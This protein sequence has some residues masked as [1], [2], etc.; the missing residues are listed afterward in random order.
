[1]KPG[2]FSYFRPPVLTMPE[3]DI[4]HPIPDLTG[5][6]TEGQIVLSREM[7]QKGIFPPIDV[8]PCLSRLMQH[9]IGAGQ[10]R[11]DHR[12]V[13]NLLYRSYAKGRELRKLEAVVGKDGLLAEDQAMLA[14]ADDFERRFVHQG[15]QR[16]DIFQTLDRGLELLKEYRVDLR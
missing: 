3:D 9:G 12:Q 14:M 6:I 10:T 4:T 15:E 8:L 7:Q 1:M 11:A 2:G 13:A 16:R 5:Y